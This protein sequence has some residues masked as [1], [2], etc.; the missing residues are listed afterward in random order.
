MDAHKKYCIVFDTKESV[1][2]YL[3]KSPKIFGQKQY[4]LPLLLSKSPQN[5]DFLTQTKV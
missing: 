5:M 3:S 4:Q 1:R 2:N